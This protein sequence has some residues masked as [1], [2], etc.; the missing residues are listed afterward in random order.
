VNCP[1]CGKFIIT[2]QALDFLKDE[3]KR[4]DKY[5]ILSYWIRNHQKKDG[6]VEIGSYDLYAA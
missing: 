5:W 4:N 6:F 3:E 1:R 2:Y